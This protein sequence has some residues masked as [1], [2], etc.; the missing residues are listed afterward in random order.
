MFRR[1][2]QLVLV[3]GRS[4]DRWD[5]REAKLTPSIGHDAAMH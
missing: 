5:Q 2:S 3:V 1:D 4:W